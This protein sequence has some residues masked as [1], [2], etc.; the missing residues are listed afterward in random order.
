MT[1]IIAEIGINANGD[2]EIAKQLMMMAKNC[3]ADLVKFQKRDVEVVY[4]QEVLDTPRDSPWG[5]T[6]REQKL[7]LEFG[8]QDY[9]EINK[10]SEEIDIPWTASAW[11]MGS[12]EFLDVF[13][14]PFHK[15]ASPM[16]TNL[17]FVEAV[18]KR[19]SLTFIS[20]G[21]TSDW[22][23]VDEALAKFWYHNTPCCL[24]HCRGEYPCEPDKTDLA[25][26]QTMQMKYPGVPIGFS[27]HAVSPLVG[28]FAAYAGA[29]AVE[30]HI[31][32]DRAMYGSDQAASLEAPG[33]RKLV[34]YCKL[35]TQV[36][37][38]SHKRMTEEEAINANKMRYWE[39]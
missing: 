11:D 23:Q 16:I 35:A 19:G 10:Y 13:N 21:M 29:T 14:L 20:T 1:T 39:D 15:V 32:L 38:S 33:L 9:L 37:G 34:E 27:S 5:T 28:A 18:A 8:M 6:T 24:M 4:S 2:V 36:K 22:R 7:G 12:L 26:M 3:G 30:A 25:V 31:T 17:E